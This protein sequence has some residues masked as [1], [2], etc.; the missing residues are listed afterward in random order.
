MIKPLEAPEN[1]P[2]VMRHVDRPRPAPIKAPVGPAQGEV[3]Q[4]CLSTATRSKE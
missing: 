1:L 2:S 4:Y 3:S